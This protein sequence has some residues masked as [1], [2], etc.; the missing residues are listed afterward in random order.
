MKK[1]VFS[2]QNVPF[3]EYLEKNDAVNLKQSTQ[4]KTHFT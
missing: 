4:Y 3:K 2:G 1:D